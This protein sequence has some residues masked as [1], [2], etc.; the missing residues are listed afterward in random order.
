MKKILPII[1]VMLLAASGC[2]WYGCGESDCPLSTVSVAHFSLLSSTN[3]ASLEFTSEVT[4]TG[5]TTADVTVKETL[6]DGT[7]IDKVVKDSVLTDTIYNK[8]A[9]LTSLS[10]PLSYTTKTTYTIH[11]DE[12]LKDVI[13]VTHRA[14]PFISDIEC[15]TMMFYKV[16]GIKYTTNSLD[17]VVIVNPDINNEEKNNFNIYYTLNE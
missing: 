1:I 3:H 11:Y 2:I 7:V 13:E 14:I 9:G 15:G 10:L 5:E 16:E 12:K 8:E 4:I 17:S 6:P